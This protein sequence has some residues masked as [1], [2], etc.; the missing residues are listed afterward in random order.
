MAGTIVV[1]RLESDASYASRINVAS[2]IQFSNTITGNVNIDNGVLFVDQNNNRVGVNTQNPGSALDISGGVFVRG[3][4]NPGGIT[5]RIVIDY[6]GNSG[7]ASISAN[8][9]AGSTLL[10]LAT[11]KSGVLSNRLLIDSDGRVTMPFQPSFSAVRTT[12]SAAMAVVV[13][14]TTYH[15]TGNHYNTTT[16]RFTAPVSGT[17]FFHATGLSNNNGGT[18]RLN[19]RVNTVTKAGQWRMPT[20]LLA[21]GTDDYMWGTMQLV[22]YLNASDYVDVYYTNDDG[23]TPLYGDGTPYTTFGGFLIG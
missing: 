12:T 16:G 15:N 14:P 4:T 9:T 10:N 18:A 7:V 23:A 21:Q 5:N 13:F 2:E 6:D 17:Y 22:Y 3:S 8:S 11:S 19:L 20:D 1:D